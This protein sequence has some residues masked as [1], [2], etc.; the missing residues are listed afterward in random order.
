M[1]KRFWKQSG[2]LRIS[3][4]A[5]S[6][7]TFNLILPHL[8][9]CSVLLDRRPTRFRLIRHTWDTFWP[10]SLLRVRNICRGSLFC[11]WSFLFIIDRKVYAMNLL[12][13]VCALS[14]RCTVGLE[15]FVT[16]RFQ[17]S[18]KYTSRNRMPNVI[19]TNDKRH[20]NVSAPVQVNSSN[21]FHEF[22]WQMQICR[23][24]SRRLVKQL[25]RNLQGFFIS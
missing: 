9:V 16:L 24:W 2:Y 22:V 14:F 13:R 11:A 4:N 18:V 23:T 6:V 21:N 1:P 5:R 3:F 8:F 12:H 25:H 10:R 20:R 19:Y 15:K 7:S 17:N